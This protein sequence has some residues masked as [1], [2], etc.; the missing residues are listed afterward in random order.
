MLRTRD[1]LILAFAAVTLWAAASTGQGCNDSFP[2]GGGGSVSTGGFGGT[3]QGQGGINYATCDACLDPMSGAPAHQCVD[4]VAACDG[5]S[6]CRALVACIDQGIEVSGSGGGAATTG[7]T[8]G[9]SSSGLGA[10]GT[11]SSGGGTTTTSDGGSSTTLGSGGSNGESSHGPCDTSLVGGCCVLDCL[12]ALDAPK[13]SK[14]RFLER[15]RCLECAVCK[16]QCSVS[17]DYCAALQD[18]GQVNC[19]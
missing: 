6:A 8:G 3:T 14:T 5:D 9:T 10:G 17:D 15:T 4:E 19:N 7:G 12:S 18:D 1:S 11:N 16:G 13:A 2:L